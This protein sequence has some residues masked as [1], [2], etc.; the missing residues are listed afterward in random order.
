MNTML[1]IAAAVGAGL[2]GGVFFAFSTFVMQALGRLRPA[3]GI[4][5]MQA[6]NITVIN[7]LCAL[8]FF[9][10][11]V[12]GVV[13][14]IRAP[15]PETI[16]ASALYWVGVLVVTGTGNVPLNERLAKVDPASREGEALWAHYLKRWTLLNHVRTVA[17][18][19]AAG[20]VVMA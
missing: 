14:A 2:V 16:A 18:L 12:V 19:A 11:G 6:I 7:A 20:L 5:A 9:G 3:E 15:G 4:A 8:A 13:L 10:T 17:A 1:S